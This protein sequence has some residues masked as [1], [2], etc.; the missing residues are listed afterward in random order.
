M[1]DIHLTEQIRNLL[2][3][4]VQ[5]IDDDRLEEWP[6]FF[7]DDGLY[8]IVPRENI[9][10]GLDLGIMHLVDKGQ[11]RDRI[12]I[13]RNATVFTLRFDR[14]MV[15]NVRV[16]NSDDGVY[17]LQAN[18]V[19]YVTDLI[20]G[21]TTLFSTGKYED[22]VVFVDGEPKFKEKRVIVDTYSVHNHISTPL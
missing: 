18:Y 19:I 11:M 16:R 1:D 21:D 5:C 12:L 4:Y 6:D 8:K 13:L 9:E 22:K 3:D 20:D 14:H 15:S 10:R 7:V 17:D 2:Y